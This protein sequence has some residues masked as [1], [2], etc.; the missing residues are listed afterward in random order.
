MR[1]TWERILSTTAQASDEDGLRAK[2]SQILNGHTKSYRYCLLTQALAKVTDP[3]LDA[4]SLQKGED[5]LGSFDARSLA[6]KV[7]APWERENGSFLGGSEDPYVSNPMRMQRLDKVP[8]KKQRSHKDYNTLHELVTSIQH[9]GEDKAQWM[10]ETILS[11]LAEICFSQSLPLYVPNRVSPSTV[12][13]LVKAFLSESSGG[14]RLQ[15]ICSAMMDVLAQQGLF[16][17][18]IAL[19]TNETNT[20]ALSPGDIVAKRGD[21]VVLAIEVKDRSLT[22]EQL[23]DAIKSA[24][25]KTTDLL[26][27]VRNLNEQ[28]SMQHLE[29]LINREF[30][31]GLTVRLADFGLLFDAFL[32]LCGEAGRRKLIESMESQMLAQGV[33]AIHRNKW[34]A[35]VDSIGK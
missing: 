19:K 14:V 29:D 32:S 7:V 10:L 26:I 30:I 17:S 2:V 24:R 31:H 18:V 12:H 33:D 20:A 23:Q 27:V 4:L 25:G 8:Q 9:S 11:V 6:S 34:R 1:R 15:S 21:T 5:L 35:L 16:D 3:T 28:D 22:T 13:A